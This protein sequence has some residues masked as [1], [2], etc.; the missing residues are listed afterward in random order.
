[1]AGWIPAD[2]ALIQSESGRAC[3]AVASIFSLC[4]LRAAPDKSSPQADNSLYDR[5]PNP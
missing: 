2:R 3:L 1:M 5:S 4:F